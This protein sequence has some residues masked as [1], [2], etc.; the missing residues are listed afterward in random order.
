MKELTWKNV[1][2][3]IKFFLFIIV[4][5]GIT[6][7]IFG[8]KQ[9][10]IW[11]AILVSYSMYGKMDLGI[12]KQQSPWIIIGLFLLIGIANRIAAIN[13][14]LGIFINFI[15]I[16]IIMYVPSTKAEQ[17][18]YMPFIL[19]Y[20]LGQTMPVEGM[21]F[22]IRMLCLLIGSIVAAIIYIRGHKDCEEKHATIGEMFHTICFTSDRFILSLK[23]AIG[24]TIA[25]LLGSLFQ[26][27]KTLWIAC[28][29]MSLTQIDFSHTKK[30]F[31]YRILSTLI[32]A[33]LF[34]L[35][36]QY[37]IPQQY[38]SIAVLVLGFIYNFVEKYHIQIVF[39]TISAL[40]SAMIL[41]DNKTAVELRILLVIIGCIIGLLINKLNLK[42]LFLKLENNKIECIDKST[43]NL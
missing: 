23:M 17:K 9:T 3:N 39:V 32:G 12:H 34:V 7:F 22:W 13:I 14:I 25:M 29:V 31:F 30:R 18:A 8:S 2:Y 38:V 33:F 42:S 28:S 26:V 36:F 15:T 4:F 16:F 5:M 21:D 19:C 1:W 11:V 35:L 24:V 40:S 27:Q 20:I 43:P 41:F 37:L 6:G 10:L